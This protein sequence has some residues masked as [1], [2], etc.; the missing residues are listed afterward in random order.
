LCRYLFLVLLSGILF[1][2]SLRRFE[3]SQGRGVGIGVVFGGEGA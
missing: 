1:E 3:G 2:V